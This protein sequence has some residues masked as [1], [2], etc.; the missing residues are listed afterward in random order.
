MKSSIESKQ[1][2]P[3]YLEALQ[4]S[5]RYWFLGQEI[6]KNLNLSNEALRLALW[7]LSKKK[8]VARVRNDFYV[9]VPPE[10]RRAGCL[11][12]L[13]LIDPLMDYL[14]L[15]YY[16]GLLSAASLHGAA[17]QQVMALQVV[18][19]KPIRNIV[20]GNQRIEF[21]VKSLMEQDWVE[22][23]KTPVSYF[24]YSEPA[25]TAFDLIKY[26]RGFG[27]LQQATTV[28]SELVEKLN[29]ERLAGLVRSGAICISLAQRLGYLLDNI[30]EAEIDLSI[31]DSAINEQQPRYVP[32]VPASSNKYYERNQRWRIFV[33]AQLDLDEL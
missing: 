4:S 19:T 18:T 6:Q 3:S 2:L 13:W 21:H 9:I 15:S 12:A 26:A 1:N 16:V 32:L 14:G 10:H 22:Y 29:L 17:H 31:L 33:N 8:V 24:K 7:R 30:V 25:I 11:P 23:G 27:Q 5:G 20:I 28:L